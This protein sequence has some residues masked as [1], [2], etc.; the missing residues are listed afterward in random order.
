MIESMLTS[1]IERILRGR[2][3]E[4][5]GKKND[6]RKYDG[7]SWVALINASWLA[8]SQPSGA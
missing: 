5:L 3:L 1:I 8:A 4:V 2:G 6:P 7:S